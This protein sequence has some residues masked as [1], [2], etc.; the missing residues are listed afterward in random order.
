[1]SNYHVFRLQVCIE[2]LQ[3]LQLALVISRLYE[4]DFETSSTYKRILQRHVLGQ[5]PQIPAHSDPFLRSMACWVLD[6]YP[7]ALDTL[8]EPPKTTED[9][10][11]FKEYTAPPGMVSFVLREVNCLP[12][13]LLGGD[14]LW[15]PGLHSEVPIKYHMFPTT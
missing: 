6:R 9:Q 10:A 13:S 1:M 3:D 11:G 4:S 12:V 15:L 14:E 2:N 8:L 7:R 5:D